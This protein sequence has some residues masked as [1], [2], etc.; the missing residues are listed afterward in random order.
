MSIKTPVGGLAAAILLFAASNAPAH[1][2]FA[3]I[4]DETKTIKVTGELTK[5]D[6]INPHIYYFVDV[7]SADGKVDRY[8]FEGMPPGF[9]RNMGLNKDMLTPSLNKQVTVEGYPAKNG[10]KTLAFGRALTLADGITIQMVG[11]DARDLSR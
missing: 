7:R 6:W 8:S 10:T 9:L 3:A 5:I 4:W 1:H 11:D 2:S